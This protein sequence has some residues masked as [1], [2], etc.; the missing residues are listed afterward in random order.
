ML[1]AC[2]EIGVDTS[3]VQRNDKPTRDVLVTFTSD[4]DR[5]FVGFGSAKNEEFA[6]CF[7]EESKL[8]LEK[9]KVL[10][11]LLQHLAYGFAST[12]CTAMIR[13]AHQHRDSTKQHHSHAA[14]KALPLCISSNLPSSSANLRPYR[15]SSHA[16]QHMIADP[17]VCRQQARS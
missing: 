12:E 3:D 9:L 15:G 2:A 16:V 5:Q 6:D 7:L 4:N 17:C 8:P 11:C 14:P 13:P 10:G 1:C